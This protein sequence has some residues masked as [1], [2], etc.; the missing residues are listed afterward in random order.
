MFMH[1]CVELVNCLLLA[2]LVRYT[3]INDFSRTD[4]IQIVKGF[5]KKLN[6]N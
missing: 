6:S 2:V 1:L 5:E 3:S 4:K